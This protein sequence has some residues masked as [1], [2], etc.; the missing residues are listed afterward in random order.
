MPSSLP[1]MVLPEVMLALVARRRTSMLLLPVE[2]EVVAV[3]LNA[4]EEEM[5]LMALKK[6]SLIRLLEEEKLKNLVWKELVWE[7]IS[8]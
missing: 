3:A 7:M 8:R 6:A 1:L 2:A 4:L 5:A